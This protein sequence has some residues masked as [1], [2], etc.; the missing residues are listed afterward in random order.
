MPHHDAYHP[1]KSGKIRVVFE[2]SAESDGR[3]INQEL[4]SGLDLTNQVVGVLT[5]F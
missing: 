5:S 2:C 1:S 3:S 4:F